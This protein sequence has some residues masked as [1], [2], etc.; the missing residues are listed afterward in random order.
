MADK[1]E[2]TPAPAPDS[3]EYKEQMMKV[4]DDGLTPSP[5]APTEEAPEETPAAPEDKPVEEP[6]APPVEE[7]PTEDKPAEDK[8]EEDAPKDTPKLD[9]DK[10]NAE[11]ME[12]GELSEATY[13]ELDAMGLPKE[14]V[15]A[16]IEGQKVIAARAAEQ[17]Y[18][19]T[20][21]EQN[22]KS[23]IDWAAANLDPA[24]IAEFNKAVAS[25]STLVREAAV[26]GLYSKYTDTNGNT[27]T[28]VISGSEG[29]N[30]ALSGYSN[31]DE[32]Y[33]D[34][35]KPAYKNDP[36]FRVQVQRRIDASRF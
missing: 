33:A 16:Y 24:D 34:M 28:P 12:K 9:F 7:T 1:P 5:A 31:W 27:T 26:K 6:A 19:V 29:T 15:N 22:Y 36:A 17:V 13:A 10:Y 32:V 35:A 3:P 25:P 18:S 2:A 30:G 11:F 20:G 23:M 4:A 14:V 21:G 8:P